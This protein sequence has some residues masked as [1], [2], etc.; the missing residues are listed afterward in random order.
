MNIREA[1][2]VSSTAS[3][4]E[5]ACGLVLGY[6]RVVTCSN[7]SEEP[8]TSFRID[9]EEAEMWWATGKVTGVWHSHCFDP[10][11]PSERD[12]E[13]AV[14]ELECLIYSVL[15]EDLGVYFPDEQGLLQLVRFLG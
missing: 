8:F 1:I 6:E 11:V 9:P 10:A 14:P 5:E 12:Q 7:V 15:D 13:L 4:P 2:A 3:F